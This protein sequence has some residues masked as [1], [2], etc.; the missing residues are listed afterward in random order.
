[1]NDKIKKITSIWKKMFKKIN[2]ITTITMTVVASAL[3]IYYYYSENAAAI[4]LAGLIVMI[5][6]IITLCKIVKNPGIQE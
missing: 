1:M 5:L 6:F 2:I 4:S 3:I